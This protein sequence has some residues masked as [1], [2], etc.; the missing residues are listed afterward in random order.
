MYH[1]HLAKMEGAALTDEMRENVRW[2]IGVTGS[3]IRRGRLSRYQRHH[4]RGP[5]GQKRRSDV[6]NQAP[7]LVR[8][9]D[10]S[11]HHYHHLLHH[12]HQEQQLDTQQEQQQLL[13]AFGAHDPHRDQ[14]WQASTEP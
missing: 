9:T 4:V 10:N 3:S 13:G 8:L 1:R 5:P 6:R 14:D 12:D 2:N 11:I 7:L